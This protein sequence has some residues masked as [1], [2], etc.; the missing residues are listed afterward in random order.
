MKLHDSIISEV[1]HEVNATSRAGQKY[2]EKTF[3]DRALKEI[4]KL[5]KIAA[6]TTDPA[7]KVKIIDKIESIKKKISRIEK[8][9]SKAIS[10]AKHAKK[11][12]KAFPQ[13]HPGKAAIGAAIAGYGGYAAYKKYKEKKK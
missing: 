5:K 4:D 3:R 8:L 10:V 9:K 12:L 6:K 13:N 7:K 2:L 1:I 11:S